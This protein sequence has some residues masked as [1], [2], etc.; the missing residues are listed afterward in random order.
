MLDG[1][2]D[3]L[4]DFF[5][6]LVEAAHHLVGGV[7]HLF[8][9]HQTDQGVDLV[10]QDLV[11]EVAVVF[12]GDPSVGRDFGHVN[13]LVN[14]DDELSFWVD[15]DKDFFLVHGFDNLAYI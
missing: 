9:H 2:L 6:L 1:Q 3:D 8:H 11:E 10:G 13:V 4:L 14:I 12:E 15:F 5:D 7:G